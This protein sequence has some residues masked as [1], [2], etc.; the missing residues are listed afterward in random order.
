[1]AEPAK[2]SMGVAGSGTPSRVTSTLAKTATLPQFAIA[3]GGICIKYAPP[4]AFDLAPPPHFI[5]C[6]KLIALRTPRASPECHRSLRFLPP[7]G[8]AT[9]MPLRVLQSSNRFA[10]PAA[11]H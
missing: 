3:D 2:I 11:R 8:R 5:V 4:G 9:A 6:S 1:M 7:L 10:Y